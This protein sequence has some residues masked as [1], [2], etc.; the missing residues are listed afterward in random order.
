MKLEI[1]KNRFNGYRDAL[2]Q[3]GLTP[4]PD[5]EIF[6][7]NRMYAE[8]MTPELL[9]REEIPDAFFTVNDDTAIGILHTVKR[10]GYRC[11][12]ISACAV[13]AT[14]RVL[15]PVPPC[16]PLWNSVAIEWVRR[17]PKS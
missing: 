8:S 17:L 11:R 3:A 2:L 13:S 1:S 12:R 7:D 6:C 10:M 15:F 5:W 9:Q 16:L 4:N 14:G